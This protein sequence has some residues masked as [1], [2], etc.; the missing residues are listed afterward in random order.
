MK[1]KKLDKRLALGKCTVSNLDTRR[2]MKV[3]GGGDTDSPC[4]PETKGFTICDTR[5]ATNCICPT[6][7]SRC[8]PC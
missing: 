7:E 4:I 8:I 3:K 6:G 1:L 5:C 2:M